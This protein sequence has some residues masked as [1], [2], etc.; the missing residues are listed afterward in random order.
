[1]SGEDVGI[2]GRG[3]PHGGVA[4]AGADHV[5]GTPGA[6]EE[7]NVGVPQIVK[8]DTGKSEGLAE[9]RTSR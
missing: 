4:H 7:R 9:S 3:E 1:M 2:V 8:A 5:G 6:G